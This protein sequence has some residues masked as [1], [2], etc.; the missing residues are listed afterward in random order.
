MPALAVNYA[1]GR[2]LSV[3]PYPSAVTCFY[4][5]HTGNFSPSFDFH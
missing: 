3:A 5:R 2:Q 4:A 1:G